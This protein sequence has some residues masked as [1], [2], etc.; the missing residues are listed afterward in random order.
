MP[1]RLLTALAGGVLALSLSLMIPTPAMAQEAAAPEAAATAYR[2]VSPTHWAYGPVTRLLEAGVLEAAADGLFH[3]SEPVTRAELV[4]MVLRARGI[5]TGTACESIFVDVA[6]DT[7]DAPAVETAYK[8]AI[9]EGKGD[10][11]FAPGDPVTRAELFTIVVR[12]LG[13]RWAANQIGWQEVNR[14]LDTF[15]DGSRVPSWARNPLAFALGD[16][17]AKGYP[18]G[19]L[20]P[21][22][23]ASRAEA[24]ALV[25]RILLDFDQYQALEIDGRRVLYRQAHD[26]TA[27]MY[28]TGEPGVGTLTYTGIHVRIG[29][30]AVDPNVIPLGSLLYVED[31]GYA[32]AA[33]IG[34][35][36]KGMRIDL[37]TTDYHE[38]AVRFGLQ[39]RRVWLLP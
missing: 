29:T 22:A 3:P 5:D 14:R 12:A 24:A 26:M 8:M 20:R 17:L 1:K 36:I 38:A 15:T 34:G 11:T 27:S 4:R 23:T 10:A 16:G 13:K 31:Y 9:V 28:T 19:S 6:C 7:R 25:D 2:D 18:D 21:A 39:P 33:D 37:Y 35:A 32:I 30:V